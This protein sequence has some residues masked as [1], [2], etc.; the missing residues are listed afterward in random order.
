MTAMSRLVMEDSSH[1]RSFLVSEL[2]S[3]GLSSVLLNELND[4]PELAGLVNL[5]KESLLAEYRLVRGA[6]QE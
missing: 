2:E 3:L 5:I 6:S 4:I 1:K